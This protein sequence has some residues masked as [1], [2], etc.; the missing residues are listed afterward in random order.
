[1][2]NNGIYVFYIFYSLYIICFS[3]ISYSSNLANNKLLFC[4]WN[5]TQK[6]NPL[7]ITIFH[8]CQTII[9]YIK[10]LNI[11]YFIWF[12]TELSAY[13]N[14]NI[15]WY[16]HDIDIAVPVFMNYHIFKCFSKSKCNKP[17]LIYT[18]ILCGY[19]KRNMKKIYSR[20]VFKRNNI[21]LYFKM[22]FMLDIWIFT[23]HEYGYYNIELCMCRFC[24]LSIVA[25]TSAYDNINR[26]Y[27]KNW[28]MYIDVKN[29]TRSSYENLTSKYAV[30][31]VTQ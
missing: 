3:I 22:K 30:D 26:I 28:Y 10:A 11:T 7:N 12:G 13:R 27:G 6:Y 5:Y 2:F 24:N 4:L 15:M 23:N 20:I 9:E 29:Y 25:L 14:G 18:K 1:M 19:I 8:Q 31:K 16:D 17:K 21:R